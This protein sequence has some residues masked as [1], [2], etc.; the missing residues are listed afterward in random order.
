[1]R[2]LADRP[3][4]FPSTSVS[5]ENTWNIPQRRNTQRQDNRQFNPRTTTVWSR[6]I[7]DSRDPPPFPSLTRDTAETNVF[8][9]E[10]KK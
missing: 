3:P 2:S 6:E 10:E 7:R 1:M 4:D 9:R 5:S 8:T